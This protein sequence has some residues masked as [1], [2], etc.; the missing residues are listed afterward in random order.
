MNLMVKMFVALFVGLALHAGRLL[1]RHVQTT[2]RTIR[3]YKKVKGVFSPND[4]CCQLQ[5]AYCRKPASKTF[6]TLCGVQRPD[7]SVFRSP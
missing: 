5:R 4:L 1:T 3:R 7:K 6:A 2:Q